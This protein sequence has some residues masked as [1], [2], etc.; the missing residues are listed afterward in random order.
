[1]MRHSLALLLA[2]LAGTSVLG[3]A[4]GTSNGT[5]GPNCKLPITNHRNLVIFGPIAT[6]GNI[7]NYKINNHKSPINNLINN[8][9]SLIPK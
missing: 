3:C 8:Q 6:G 5:G 1:M 7:P 2:S 9:R 4:Q